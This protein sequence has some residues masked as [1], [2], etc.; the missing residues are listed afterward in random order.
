MSFISSATPAPKPKTRNA[1]LVSVL[2]AAFL[3][4]M[5][6]AQLFTFEDFPAVLGAMWL[7]GSEAWMPVYAG[8]IVTLEVLALPFLLGMRLSVA[9]RVLSIVFGWLVIAKWLV[10]CVGNILVGDVV[11]SG[12]L[13]ATVILPVGWWSIS[14]C[15]ALGVLALWVAWGMWPLARKK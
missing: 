11:N 10:I 2:L 5:I 6:V 12:L 4:I 14:F 8:V 13:G 15:V 7:P 3:V 9:M 1:W